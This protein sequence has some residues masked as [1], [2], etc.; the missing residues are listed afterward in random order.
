MASKTTRPWP[1]SYVTPPPSASVSS[2]PTKTCLPRP[3]ASTAPA[4]TGNGGRHGS[5]DLYS[6]GERGEEPA[7]SYCYA[8]APWVIL[9]SDAQGTQVMGATAN[10]VS[11]PIHRVGTGGTIRLPPELLHRFGITEGSEIITEAR[12]EGILIR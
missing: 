8:D 1:P 7:A 3:W 11:L 4:R 6:K 10:N 12:E 2:G 5:T 9:Q